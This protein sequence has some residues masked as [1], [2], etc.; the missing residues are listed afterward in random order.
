MENFMPGQKTTALRERMRED[1]QL[2]NYSPLTE[3]TYLA[4]VRWYATY[5]KRSP[6]ELELEDVRK[7]LIHLTEERNVSLSHRFDQ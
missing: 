4:H 5:F 7:Y 2:R 6:L 3:K 1:L